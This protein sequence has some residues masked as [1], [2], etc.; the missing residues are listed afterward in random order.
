MQSISQRVSGH[1]FHCSL[2]I[3]RA[4]RLTQSNETN[5]TSHNQSKR[6]NCRRQANDAISQSAVTIQAN[7][8]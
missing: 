1:W 7:P 4:A 2:L 3:P 5:V 6:P 8:V